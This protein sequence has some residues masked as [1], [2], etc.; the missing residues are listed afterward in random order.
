M[1]IDFKR[2]Q[3]QKQQVTQTHQARVISEFQITYAVGY[4][5]SNVSLLV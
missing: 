4:L 3:Q 5:P 1:A 2:T